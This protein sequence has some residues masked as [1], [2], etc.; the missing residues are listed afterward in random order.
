MERKT[1]EDIVKSADVRLCR[2]FS[3]RNHN[4]YGFQLSKC[5]QPPHLINLIESGS[6][7]AVGGLRIYDVV[8]AVNNRKTSDMKFIELVNFLVSLRNPHQ[9]LELLVVEQHIYQVLKKKNLTIHHS[10]VK[11]HTCPRVMPEEY[12]QFSRNTLRTC[13][14]Y[15]KTTETKFGFDIV[16][17]HNDTGV[18]IQE[19]SP[20]SPAFNAGLRKCDRLIEL[21][22]QCVEDSPSNVII[23][24]LRKAAAQRVIKLAVKGTEI[25][26]PDGRNA[27]SM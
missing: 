21:N 3:W 17:G 8:L 1:S 25:V 15:L 23:E 14:V 18:F 24:K 27:S 13:V 22:D 4:G 7:A 12:V 11:I 6:P 19:V 20:H 26:V 5:A 2:L 10:T 9:P 16:D